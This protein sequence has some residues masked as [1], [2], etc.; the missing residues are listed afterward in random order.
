MFCDA[1]KNKELDEDEG[2][3][4]QKELKDDSIKYSVVHLASN[5]NASY[6]CGV[7]LLKT[8]KEAE[9]LGALLDIVI[10]EAALS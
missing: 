8:T 6:K 4:N 2:W 3:R 5:A 10:I 7:H 9:D 1:V